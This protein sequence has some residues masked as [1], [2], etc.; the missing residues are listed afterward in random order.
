MD[1]NTLEYWDNIFQH[2]T[3][4]FPEG[5]WLYVCSR[6]NIFVALKLKKNWIDFDKIDI[7]FAEILTRYVSSKRICLDDIKDKL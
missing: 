4:M 7:T 5:H 6:L 1:E 3:E 2:I